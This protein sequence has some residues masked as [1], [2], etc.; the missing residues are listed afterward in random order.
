M[1]C[2]SGDCEGVQDE[3]GN[4]LKVKD[5]GDASAFKKSP[6]LSKQKTNGLNKVIGFLNTIEDIPQAYTLLIGPNTVNDS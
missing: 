6:E 4:F 2:L 5:S 1:C 3:S